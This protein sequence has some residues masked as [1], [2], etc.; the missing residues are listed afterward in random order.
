MADFNL[1]ISQ[2]A[3]RLDQAAIPWGIFG[4][5][6]AVTYGLQRKPND[7]DILIPVGMGAQAAAIF[8]EAQVECATW[9]AVNC[10]VL[11]GIEIIAG[12]SLYCHFELDPEMLARIRTVTMNGAHV[13]V[14]SLEDNL[15]LKAMLGRGAELGKRDWED[16][17]QMLQHVDRVDWE[18]LRWRLARC[19]PQR[20][21]DL[22]HRI[23]ALRP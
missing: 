22:Y 21:A 11:P 19:E 15:A 6:A 7:I 13:K 4:S 16:V 23:L 2:V 1:S 18:Y 3:Q 10:L 12:L 8:P 5:A 9:G 20:Q 17:A 14:I